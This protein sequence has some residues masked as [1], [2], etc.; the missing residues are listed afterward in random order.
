MKGLF[1]ENADVVFVIG[2]FESDSEDSS[3]NVCCEEVVFV[4]NFLAEEVGIGEFF[5]KEFSGDSVKFGVFDFPERELITRMVFCCSV[6][7]L[8]CR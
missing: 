3:A 7:L 1:A 6:L 5:G 4:V 8:R 2:A